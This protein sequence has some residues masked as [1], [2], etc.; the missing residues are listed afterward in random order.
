MT[1]SDEI[2]CIY[3]EKCL[4][5]VKS[6]ATVQNYLG[7]LSSCYKR[8]GLD[9]SVFDAYKVR[10]AITGIKKNVRH[11]PAPS[12]P[13]T[14]GLLKRVLRVVVKLP[15]G[16][17]ICFA[18]IMM[19]HSF[20]R[21]SN[22]CANTSFEFDPT[23]QFVRKDV[24]VRNDGLLVVHK[25][26]KSHQEASHQGV[27]SIPAVPHSVLCPKDAFQRMVRLSLTIHPLQPLLVYM[28]G[29]H[30]TAPYIRRIWKT[31]LIAIGIPNHQWYSL[32]GIRRG[33]ATYVIDNDPTACEDIKRH[34]YWASDAVDC[35]LP[36]TSSKV[37]QVMKKLQ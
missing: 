21:Q 23:R 17:T 26:S 30:M 15:E 11:V 22:F 33:A 8:M 9:A 16:H 2:V 34:G 18:L 14:P 32:H 20:C 12:M 29:N 5:T 3:F 27:I 37:F 28:D 31:A 6:P 4:Q 13:V 10:N 25:W 35:Y 7:A 19:F 24:K 1:I 36:K